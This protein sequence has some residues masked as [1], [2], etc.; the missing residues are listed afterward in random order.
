MS[1]CVCG[2]DISGYCP[3]TINCA[4]FLRRKAEVPLK[5]EHNYLG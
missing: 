3:G 5:I 2:N 4:E 1:I